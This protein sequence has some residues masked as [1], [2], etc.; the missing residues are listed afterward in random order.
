MRTSRA[1]LCAVHRSSHGTAGAEAPPV[2]VPQMGVFS[3]LVAPAV[4][5][6]T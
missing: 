1:H 4:P 5:E 2:K 6:W 3:S